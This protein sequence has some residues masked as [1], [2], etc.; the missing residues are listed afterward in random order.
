MQVGMRGE[1]DFQDRL[2]SAMRFEF[3]G[4]V[5]KERGA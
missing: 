3:G 2:L 4:Q 1:V 5:E